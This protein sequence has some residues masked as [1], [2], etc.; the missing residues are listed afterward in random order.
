[1]A[2]KSAM[3]CGTRT[4]EPLEA[5]PDASPKGREEG[6][7]NQP[8]PRLVK[9]LAKIQQ[10]ALRSEADLQFSR[11]VASACADGRLSGA[12]RKEL[13]YKSAD[14]LIKAHNVGKWVGR[15]KARHRRG[16]P[17]RPRE[18]TLLEQAVYIIGSTTGPLKIGIAKDV[19]KRLS[20]IQTGHPHRLFV[21]CAYRFEAGVAPKVERYCHDELSKHRCNGE[22]FDIHHEGAIAVLERF[23]SYFNGER[24]V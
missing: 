23:A 6:A 3:S 5:E 20:G 7:E 4:G 1:V 16:A 18:K 10:G 17:I 8:D 21:I 11:A 12:D 14:A 9:K 13:L 22:W 2:E 19:D 15:R 24:E